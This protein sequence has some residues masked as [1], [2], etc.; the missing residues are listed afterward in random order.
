MLRVRILTL[1]LAIVV[2][3]GV[4]VGCNKTQ[5]TPSNSSKE[6]QDGTYYA[7]A[8]DFDGTGW[9]GFVTLEVKDGKIISA[10]WN[11]IHKDG[12]DDKDTLSKSGDYKMVENGGAQAEWH[13]QAEKAE[14]YLIEKQDPTDIQYKDKE[15]HTDAITG[16]SIHVKEFFELAKEALKGAEK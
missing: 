2:A 5:G 7:E 14:A 1:G 15:G 8:D 16:A 3:A 10:D 4:L 9:K 6:Y 12:G 13:E 11:A